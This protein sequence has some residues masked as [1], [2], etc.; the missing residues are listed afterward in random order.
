MHSVLA[1]DPGAGGAEGFFKLLSGAP[2]PTL[3]AAFQRY[4]A[5]AFPHHLEAT[6]ASGN[7][8]HGLSVA[9]DSTSEAMLQLGTDESYELNVTSSGA[10]LHARTV[11]GALR[12]LET[13]SQMIVFDYDRHEYSLPGAPWAIRDA[14][15][16]THRG[17][18][19]DTSRHFEPLAA[20]RRVVES[21]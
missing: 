12:G 7:T 15:R 14:P 17:V 20:V 13:F 10:A 19:L 6:G 11:Y 18:M 4:H 5:L 21:M 3:G 16:F 9:V 1:V 8:L 2:C